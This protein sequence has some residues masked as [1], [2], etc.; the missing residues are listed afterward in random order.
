MRN[1][2]LT[3]TLTLIWMGLPTMILKPKAMPIQMATVRRTPT[4]TG[5]LTLM[6]TRN[7]TGLPMPIQ[8][9][10]GL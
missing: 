3:E 1:L 4:R 10:M 7:A 8:T 5:K 9:V 2:M 6:L